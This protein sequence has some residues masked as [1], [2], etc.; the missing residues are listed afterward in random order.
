MRYA[1]FTI[2]LYT[3]VFSWPNATAHLTNESYFANL[4]LPS[5][6]RD[7]ENSL[8]KSGMKFMKSASVRYSRGLNRQTMF[9]PSDGEHTPGHFV[10]CCWSSEIGMWMKRLDEH[11]QELQS[12]LTFV[13]QRFPPQG[14]RLDLHARAE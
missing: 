7:S 2:E 14:W 1:F 11:R 9:A 6:V 5:I 12:S 3:H 4:T 10:R 8:Q 13:D